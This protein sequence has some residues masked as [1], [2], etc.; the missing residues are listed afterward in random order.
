MTENLTPLMKQYFSIKEKHP[1]EVL[2]FR[3]GDFYEMFDTDAKEISR[4]LNLTLTHR[5]SSPMCGIPFHAAKN[6]IKRLLDLGKKIAICE[7]LELA[8]PGKALVKRDVIQVITPA[9]VVEDEFLNSG[10]YN[11]LLSIYGHSACYC[12]ISTGDFFL[13]RLDEKNRISSIQTLLEQINPSEVLI[14]E[15]E[16]FLNEELRLLLDQGNFLVTKLPNWYF[17]NK[18]G[19]KLIKEYSINNSYEKYLEGP[20]DKLK[21]VCLSLLRYIKATS[22]STEIQYFDFKLV[23]DKKYLQIDESSRKNLELFTNNFDSSKKY[24]LF[25]AIDKTTTSAGQRM[26]KQWLSFPLYNIEEILFRQDWI[27]FFIKSEELRKNVKK[28]LNNS[29]DIKRLTNRVFLKRAKPFDL[30]GIKYTLKSFL[31]I[32]QLEPEKFK[33]LLDETI[34]DNEIEE[35]KALIIILD[36][37]INEDNRGPFVSGKVILDGFDKE[38]DEIRKLIQNHNQVF[39]NYLNKIKKE[40]GITNIKLVNSRIS[41]YVI[42]VSKGQL[43]KVPSEFTRKQTLVNSE[44]FTTK[45]LYDFEKQAVLNEKKADILEREIYEKVCEFCSNKAKILNLIGNFLSLVDCFQSLSSLAIE[46]DYH[47]PIITDTSEL[48]IIKG[49][50]PVVENNIPPGSFVANDTSLNPPFVLMTGPNMAGKSTYLRQNALIVLLAQI[51]SF[52][53]AE[54]AVIGLTDKIFCRVGA[55]DNLA[56]GESTFLVEMKEASFIIRTCTKKSLVIM[57]E[58]GRGTSTQDGMSIAYAIIDYLKNNAIKTLFATHYHELT[59]L[60]DKDVNLLTLEV[61]N[62]N[63]QI[64]FLRKVIPGVAKSSYALQVAKLAGMPYQV[65]KNASKFQKEH[66]ADYSLSGQ[67]D[68]FIDA[69]LDSSMDETEEKLRL[70]KEKQEKILKE[71]LNLDLDNLS[72]FQ[73]LILLSEFKEKIR[74]LLEDV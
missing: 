6:Y 19:E 38:L 50:H 28:Y 14:N 33:T 7:Q 53:P 67:R 25:N 15:D 20:R 42:E 8:G 31:S 2:F 54:K 27:K 39:D 13:K 4:L 68:L 58:I 41:G 3:L 55:S 46:K 51:G 17:S 32:Y 18:N 9:T 45:E 72:P 61:S 64:K 10:S 16:Y 26:L 30:V 57:D 11:F 59:Y 44:R 60:G 35:I 37:S 40:T 12:D 5:G 69:A 56:R 66:F 34:E 29:M 71:I 62:E 73:A 70:I 36:K 21:N 49:R 47:C 74:C 63:N 43:D 23:N 48:T 52:I 24:S 1:N 22:K 65:L